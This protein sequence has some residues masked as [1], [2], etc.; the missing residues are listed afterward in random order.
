MTVFRKTLACLL[1]IF[2][3]LGW[4][5]EP[6]FDPETATDYAE[7]RFNVNYL[8]V[9]NAEGKEVHY[10]GDTIETIVRLMELEGDMERYNEHGFGLALSKSFVTPFSEHFTVQTRMPLTGMVQHGPF[11]DV[12]FYKGG[13]SIGYYAVS[14]YDGAATIHSNGLI[15]LSGN[16]E[17]VSVDFFPQEGF[18]YTCIHLEGNGKQNVRLQ[19]VEGEIVAEGLVGEYTVTKYDENSIEISCETFQAE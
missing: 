3:F 1:V 6:P 17:K 8:N 10:K 13:K 5:E 12:G 15:E 14:C 9:T 2:L 19:L 4:K 11:F 18:D 16:N 7:I